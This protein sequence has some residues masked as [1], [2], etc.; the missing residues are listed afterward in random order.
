MEKILLIGLVLIG[1][2]ILILIGVFFVNTL[3]QNLEWEYTYH[4][5]KAVCNEDNY[6]RDYEV[7]C[8]NTEITEMR[9][10]GAAVQFA[11]NWKDPR[12]E[13]LKNSFC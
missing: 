2:L 9:F 3:N 8:R 12:E 6:C 4:H 11:K 10:T 1:A 13:E 5:T 7:F